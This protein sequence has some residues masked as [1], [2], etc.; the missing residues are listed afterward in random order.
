MLRSFYCSVCDKQFKSS[1]QYDE[2]TN[3]ISHAHMARRGISSVKVLPSVE[4]DAR[5]EKERRRDEK[6][7]QKIAAASGVKIKK[8]HLLPV[9]APPPEIQQRGMVTKRAERGWGRASFVP[10]DTEAPP[11]PRSPTPPHG[12]QVD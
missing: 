12:M 10:V 5:K 4:L 3:S 2:H 7:L 8:S 6:E 1:P 9:V 11:I